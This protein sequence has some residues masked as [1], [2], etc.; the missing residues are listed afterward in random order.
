MSKQKKGDHNC[1]RGDY[2]DGA[3]ES[4]NDDDVMCVCVM[5]A[6]GAAMDVHKDKLSAYIW[7]DINLKNV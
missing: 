2:D 4:R 5:V 7:A 1:K 6:A 3:I